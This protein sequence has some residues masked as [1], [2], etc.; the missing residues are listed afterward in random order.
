MRA[1]ADRHGI[2][3][4]LRHAE[5]RLWSADFGMQ[6][7]LVLTN[8]AFGPQPEVEPGRL[9]QDKLLRQG[10]GGSRLRRRRAGRDQAG[11]GQTFLPGGLEAADIG[12]ASE[13]GVQLE[14]G[15]DGEQGN[16]NG[17]GDNFEET[18]L[19]HDSMTLPTESGGGPQA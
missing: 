11:R 14:P 9:F 2:E 19:S 16:P 17:P 7:L 13:A 3:I 12:P 8:P 6:T 1:Q 5:D 18:E 4:D 15:P 10:L